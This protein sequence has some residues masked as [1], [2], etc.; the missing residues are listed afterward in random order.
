MSVDQERE[1]PKTTRS[2]T[3][4][5]GNNGGQITGNVP[6]E[7]TIQRELDVLR[8]RRAGLSFDAIALQVG[9]GDKSSASKAYHRALARDHRPLVAEIR[10]L[11]DGRLDDLLQAVWTKAMR[12]DA[13]SVRNAIRISERRARL[14]GLDHADGIAERLVQIE[15]DKL[16][17]MAIALKTTL[18][19]LGLADRSLEARRMMMAELRKLALVDEAAADATIAELEAGTGSDEQPA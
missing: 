15:Q 19:Q 9:Y 7:E 6:S 10:Q 14:H 13:A 17:L 16:K 11:E 8:L 12:G 5:R 4:V 1:Q 3:P 18:E 2:G